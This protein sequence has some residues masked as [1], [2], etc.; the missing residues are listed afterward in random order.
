MTDLSTNQ[1]QALAVPDRVFLAAVL[2]CV[3]GLVAIPAQ[4]ADTSRWYRVEILVVAQPAGGH[5]EVWPALPELSYPDNL[6]FLIDR[7]DIPRY[8]AQLQREQSVEVTV[9]DPNQVDEPVIAKSSTTPTAP[10]E[11]FGSPGTDALDEEGIPV[12]VHTPN[13]PRPFLP[14]HEF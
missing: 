11:H 1:L 6:Q 4:S 8:R 5:S 3:L 12:D 10:A 7:G 2:A 9:A 13:G 14:V